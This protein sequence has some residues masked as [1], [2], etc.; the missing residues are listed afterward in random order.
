VY[1]NGFRKHQPVIN[2][3]DEGGVWGKKRYGWFEIEACST[4]HGASLTP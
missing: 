3:D 4:V 2:V 1:R